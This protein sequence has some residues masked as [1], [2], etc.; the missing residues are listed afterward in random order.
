[1]VS[2]NIPEPLR[3]SR[4]HFFKAVAIAAGAAGAAMPAAA[5]ADSI[6]DGWGRGN[7]WGGGGGGG[8]PGHGSGGGNPGGGGSWGGGGGSSYCFLRGTHIRTEDG[9]RPIETLAVGDQLPAHF[10]QIATIREI[11]SFTVERDSS[12]NW[13]V[14]ARL[15]R[16]RAGALG[17]NIPLRDL[18]VTE[19]HAVFL[20]DVLIPV[21]SLLN[22]KTISH[23]SHSGTDTLEYFHIALDRHDVIDAEGAACESWRDPQV[24]AC[25]P[26][27][28]FQ[29][30]RS[31]IFS[32]LRSAIAPVAD[33]RQPLDLIRDGLE[34]R[35]GI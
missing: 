25:A 20:D 1:V 32:R 16:I 24:Q 14:E 10:S 6:G 11:V 29:G 23:D 12:G 28:E 34:I 5:R 3:F 30:R 31:E 22:G 4:R 8:E 13:P 15:V 19:A 33:W 7:P 9:Y 35:A 17:E 18:F 2:D 27:L 21:G 26:L